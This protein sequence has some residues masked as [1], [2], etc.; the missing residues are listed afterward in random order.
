MKYAID[1]SRENELSLKCGR[2]SDAS[3][4]SIDIALSPNLGVVS[5]KNPHP[6]K[7]R[8]VGHKLKQIVTRIFLNRRKRPTTDG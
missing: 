1:L 8:Y 7:E 3:L 5:K 2:N 4:T 6:L